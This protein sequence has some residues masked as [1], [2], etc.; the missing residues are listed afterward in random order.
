[1]K[2]KTELFLYQCLWVTDVMFRP[3]WRSM[4]GSFEE[5]SY[6][7][8][9]LRQ[10]Q[11][12]EAEGWVE[13]RMGPDK[14]ERVLRLT[15]KGCLKALGGR[16]PEERWNRSWDGKWRMI[17]FDLPEEKRGLRNELRKQLKAAHFGGLQLSAWITPDPLDSLV[18]SLKKITAESGVLTFFEGATCGGAS[19]E[20]LVAGAWDF[21]KI[22]NAF[23]DHDNHL[24][25][26]PHPEQ[27]G[28]R[29]LL[30]EWAREEKQSWS[31]CMT[32]DPL[33]P[34]VLWPKGYRGETAWKNRTST[35]RRAG[36][37]ATQTCDN[38]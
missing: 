25:T 18:E 10:I 20:E 11:R 22:N 38:H 32:L 21:A 12:L 37:I 28:F 16:H 17:L 5:W 1:M 7:S 27:K 24:G 34:R 31:H 19:P 2:A 36:S 3:T 13:S 33:L 26:L 15:E 30:L 9:L 6:R 4:T 29:D 14:T 8:G 23:E 35:L